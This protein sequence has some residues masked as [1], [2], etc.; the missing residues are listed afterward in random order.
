MGEVL[1]TTGLVALASFF[2]IAL[3]Y[4]QAPAGEVEK[5]PTSPL[6]VSHGELIGISVAALAWSL[7][8]WYGLLIPHAEE[9]RRVV[10]MEYKQFLRNF[11]MVPCQIVR[12]GRRL[13]HRV[14]GY[15]RWLRTFFNTYDVI[16]QLGFP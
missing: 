7:K 11:I 12:T 9:S 2:L 6:E 10:R 13:L 4:R 8:A 16:R 1:Y 3:V 15:N 14:L 5:G